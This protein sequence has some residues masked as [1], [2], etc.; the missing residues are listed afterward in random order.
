VFFLPGYAGGRNEYATASIDLHKEPSEWRSATRESALYTPAIMP[1]SGHRIQDIP[2]CAVFYHSSFLMRP[3]HL[4]SWE[5]RFSPGPPSSSHRCRMTTGTVSRI[6]PEPHSI[7]IKP[8]LDDTIGRGAESWCIARIWSAATT[9]SRW[10][11]VT[12]AAVVY[13]IMDMVIEQ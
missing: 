8:D 4:H 3:L 6:E 1:H 13:Q 9:G 10:M 12:G 7:Q 5:S 11:I 2:L